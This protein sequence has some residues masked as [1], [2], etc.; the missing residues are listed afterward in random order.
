M[1]APYQQIAAEITERIRRG[2]LRP[3]DRVPSTRQIT[4]EWG[5]AIATATK[6]LAELRSRGAVRSIPG[7]G[8]VVAGDDR[9]APERP[10]QRRAQPVRGD[11]HERIIRTAISIADAENLGAVSMRRIAVDLGV[12]TMS[13]YRWIPSKD[14]LLTGM[15]DA[16]LGDGEWPVPPKGWR[17][18]LEYVARRQW[19][20]Y[21]D[22]PWLGQIVSLSRPQLAPRAMMH[23]EWSLRALDRYD[24]DNTTRLYIV[25][26]IFGYVKGAAAGLDAERQAERDTGI[27]NEQWIKETDEQFAPVIQSGRFPTLAKL[28]R[29][30]DVDFSLESLFEFGL[31]VLLDGLTPLLNRTAVLY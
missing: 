7:V 31:T 15:L 8:T 13:L 24:L 26:T 10:A 29:D 27:D 3:G 28:D 17:A 14:D 12:P 25:L 19:A 16:I 11:M 5:V 18:Q 6:V 22:H 9:D 23:T 30:A 21:R 2:D 4:T 1:T 20:G